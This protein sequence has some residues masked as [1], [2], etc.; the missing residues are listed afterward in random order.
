MER[1]RGNSS[2]AP[3]NVELQTDAG[4]PQD[5]SRPC[6]SSPATA[7]SLPPSPDATTTAACGGPMTPNT[8]LGTATAA[9]ALPTPVSA[10]LTSAPSATPITSSVPAAIVAS[11]P[12]AATATTPSAPS[13][14]PSPRPSSAAL[15]TAPSVPHNTVLGPAP[16]ESS[17][18]QPAARASQAIA[19]RGNTRG[20][21][22]APNGDPGT[23]TLPEASRP[24]RPF[25]RRGAA[26]QPIPREVGH[27]GVGRDA[28]GRKHFAEEA[29]PDPRCR[30]EE[31]GQLSILVTEPLNLTVTRPY[32]LTQ[33][34]TA[35][36]EKAVPLY[37]MAY[38]KDP[39]L[40][41]DVAG[42]SACGWFQYPFICH[43]Q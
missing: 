5:T 12:Q 25:F 37:K 41:C 38:V 28:V 4:P 30:I 18:F 6:A 34:E 1:E 2:Q 22:I 17:A 31:G 21:S 29:Y 32:G 10:A 7:T 9:T 15:P 16:T 42:R 14:C 23:A 20:P 43:L 8:A 36:L 3:K 19:T 11:A 26:S 27:Q 24:S 33:T 40:G 35:D 13:T 39:Y